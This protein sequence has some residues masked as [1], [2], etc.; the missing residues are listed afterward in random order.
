MRRPPDLVHEHALAVAAGRPIVV[1]GFDEVG[2]GAVA[3][4]VSVG[5]CALRIDPALPPPSPPEGLTD[6]KLLTAARRRALFDDVAAWSAAVATGEVD[7]CDIDRWGLST[8]LTVASRRA[9]ARARSLGVRIDAAIVDGTFDWLGRDVGMVLDENGGLLD[10]G[11]P[12]LTV[13]T[14][15]KADVGCGTVA[16]ASVIAKVTRDRLMDALARDH[17]HYGWDRNK[18]YGTPD[19]TAVIDRLGTTV[20]HRRSWRIGAAR[21]STVVADAMNGRR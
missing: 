5:L 12:P 20:L 6:S 15:V 21:S 9:L 16:G 3:G 8:A 17:P 13:V 19:H 1:A 4:P 18:G 10:L 11:V 2:R 7:A 14:R